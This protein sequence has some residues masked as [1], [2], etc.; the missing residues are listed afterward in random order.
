MAEPALKCIFCDH[1]LGPTT[2][3]EH[4]LLNALGGRKTARRV[5]CSEWNSRFGSTIDDAFAEQVE[6]IRNLL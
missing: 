5:I 4:I 6:I 3:P 2:K 1:T